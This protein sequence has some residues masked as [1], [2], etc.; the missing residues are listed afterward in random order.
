MVAIPS[1]VT[2]VGG[3]PFVPKGYPAGTAPSELSRGLPNPLTPTRS[4][5][6]ASTGTSPDVPDTP[7]F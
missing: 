3:P 1:W 7:D 5:A 4:G 2:S 6:V